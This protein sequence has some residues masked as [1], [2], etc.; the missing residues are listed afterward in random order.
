[1]I[2]TDSSGSPE[3]MK[4]I[5]GIAVNNIT[6]TS[7]LKYD[8]SANSALSGVYTDPYGGETINS[9]HADG[10]NDQW[11]Q[12]RVIVYSADIAFTPTFSSI[13]IQYEP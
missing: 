3:E 4:I 9:A 13:R 6:F 12:Y 2:L 10:S 7:P 1:M 8:Y 11:F 5:Q